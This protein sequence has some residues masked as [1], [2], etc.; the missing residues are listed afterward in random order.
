MAEASTLTGAGRIAAAFEAARADGRAALMPYMMGAFP[1]SATA[2]EVAEAYVDA[3]ADLVELGVPF[4]DPL[5]DGPVIH[6]AA[7]RA[8]AAGATLDSA[9]AACERI[10][11]RA[12]VVVMAYANMALARGPEPFARALA[13][14]GASGAIVPDLPPEAGGEIA[15][16]MRDAGLALVPLVAPTTPPE[17][18][19]SICAGAEGFVYL[20]SDTRTTGERDELPAGLADL[21][22]ATRADSPVPVAVGF[23]IS[24]PEQV[25]AVGRIADG[26]IIGSRLVR[27]AAEAEGPEAASSAVRQFLTT[28]RG[29]LG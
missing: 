6:A 1:D 12:P 27:A 9:L 8:L 16:A 3:G 4:S 23:G 10:A 22:A 14:A 2:S 25:A 29:A 26:V 20:V 15:T 11:P 17:R 18:R 7:T 19:R 21:V 13:A 24:T 5:A 28:V